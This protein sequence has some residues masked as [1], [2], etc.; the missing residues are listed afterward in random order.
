M[1]KKAIIHTMIQKCTKIGSMGQLGLLQELGL[2]G[3]T[4]LHSL[5]C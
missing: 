1:W 5:V 4:R 3:N 2:L